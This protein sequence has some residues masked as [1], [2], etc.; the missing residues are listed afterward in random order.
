MLSKHNTDPNY[1]LHLVQSLAYARAFESECVLITCNA[2]GDPQEGFMG[3][4]GVWAPL[5]G[6]VGG[7]AG[8]EVGVK[9][10]NVDMRVLK[11]R[12]VL[13]PLGGPRR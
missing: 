6:R 9:V 13:F 11:V 12:T 8:S 7:F 4:S 1:E 3:G 2:G 10:V 5:L